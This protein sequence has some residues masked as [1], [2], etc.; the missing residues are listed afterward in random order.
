MATLDKGDART[1]AKALADAGRDGTAMELAIE[2]RAMAVAVLR[3]DMADRE[4]RR[5][6]ER[7]AAKADTATLR[8]RL[9]DAKAALGPAQERAIDA[10]HRMK[11]GAT[12]F[13]EPLLVG[14]VVDRA[15][16]GAGSTP[17]G[18]SA[19]D[20]KALSEGYSDAEGYFRLKGPKEPFGDVILWA[21]GSAERPS[22]K[23]RLTREQRM[24]RSTVHLA[25]LKS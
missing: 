7:K 19:D 9:K 3:A 5:A 21:G 16:K 18:V 20:G 6:V 23:T 1:F 17:V 4:L 12:L 13:G 11:A 2:E 24:L 10:S 14:R 25:M 8:L 15:G 22:W